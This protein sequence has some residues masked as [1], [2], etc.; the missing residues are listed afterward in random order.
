MTSPSVAH[1][2]HAAFRLLFDPISL[3]GDQL[4]WER[5][6]EKDGWVKAVGMRRTQNLFKFFIDQEE[7][8]HCGANR[9]LYIQSLILDNCVKKALK[10]SVSVQL[11]TVLF[12]STCTALTIKTWLTR[13]CMAD[14]GQSR[15]QECWGSEL[16]LLPG[17]IQKQQQFQTG[18]RRRRREKWEDS[19]IYWWDPNLRNL[20]LQTY[21]LCI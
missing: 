14:W 10:E 9:A 17:L 5:R 3:I 16:W 2:V 11:I 20:Q 1:N 8:N 19:Q 21:T 18:R 13:S 4:L 12:S 15:D 7:N 6:E